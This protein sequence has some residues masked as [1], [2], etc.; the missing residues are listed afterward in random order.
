MMAKSVRR[1]LINRLAPSR[2]Q[3]SPRS[4]SRAHASAD[5]SRDGSDF[6]NWVLRNDR[7][8]R[9]PDKR[10]VRDCLIATRGACIAK[11][12]Y[13]EYV[14]PRLPNT[15]PQTLSVLA[16]LLESPRS[17]HYGYALSQLTGLKSGTLYP[18][19]LRLAD[20]GW[21]ETRWAEPE[22]PGRPP[23][24][25]YRLTG[26]GAKT[27]RTKLAEAAPLRMTRR[28]AAVPGSR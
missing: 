21:L 28:L 25:T 22:Q 9:T 4:H 14:M 11:T 24:H 1:H 15:S 18:I 13:V 26:A 16:L 5:F 7:A 12:T 27:A 23:R 3:R 20:Q 2:H 6:Q 19:L 17:W 8:Q 10:E